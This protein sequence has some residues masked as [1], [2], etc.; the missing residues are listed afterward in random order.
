VA[1][2]RSKLFHLKD[3]DAVQFI[4]SSKNEGK[5]V[6]GMKG[7]KERNEGDEG[8][9]T[10]GTKSSIFWNKAPCNPTKVIFRVNPEGGGYIFLRNVSCLSPDCT[11]SNPRR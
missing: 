4:I 7:L 9:N 6:K 5:D 10:N 1:A 8:E 11:E 3:K 2:I